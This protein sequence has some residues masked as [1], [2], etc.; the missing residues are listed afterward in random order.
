MTSSAITSAFP[1]LIKKQLFRS[2]IVID[3]SLSFCCKYITQFRPFVKYDH[4]PLIQSLRP[5]SEIPTR[6]ILN[7]YT[8]FIQPHEPRL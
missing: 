1:M 8:L 2:T 4:T 6:T 7:S 5:H 3:L